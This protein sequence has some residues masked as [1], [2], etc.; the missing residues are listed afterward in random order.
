MYRL[1]ESLYQY[2][3]SSFD[4]QRN[5]ATLWIAMETEK[6]CRNF[7]D[8]MLAHEQR[9]DSI[10]LELYDVRL[11]DIREHISQFMNHQTVRTNIYS[12]TV[13]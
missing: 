2:I 5:Q 12:Y 4:Q 1:Q 10:R 13:N 7:E 3:E 11:T 9:Y 6:H 8:K